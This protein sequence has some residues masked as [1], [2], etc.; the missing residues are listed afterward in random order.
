M[1]KCMVTGESLLGIT[2]YEKDASK[3][4][5]THALLQP[6]ASEAADAAE[7]RHLPA[8]SRLSEK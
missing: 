4:T 5:H 1:Y 2:K 7:N 6:A 8:P 3:E